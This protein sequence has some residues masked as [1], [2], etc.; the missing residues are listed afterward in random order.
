MFYQLF[1]SQ[2][3][4]L[5]WCFAPQSLPSLPLAKQWPN[6]MRSWTDYFDAMPTDFM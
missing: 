1:S 2:L 5:C 3:I 4:N 6:N